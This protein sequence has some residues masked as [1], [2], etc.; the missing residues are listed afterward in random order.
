M[1]VDGVSLT[2][3]DVTGDVLLGGGHP[4]HPCRSPP[5]A[6]RAPAIAVNL[7]VDVIAKYAAR[8]L[9]A[10]LESPYRP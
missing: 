3:V 5:S 4:A 7:E 9:Q 6:A 8:L 1:T 2:V 10:G